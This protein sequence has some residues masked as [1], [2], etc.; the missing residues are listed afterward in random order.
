M[1]NFLKWFISLAAIGSAIGLI[2]AYFCKSGC[3][4]D[5]CDDSQNFTED[6]DFDL[7]SDLEPVPER[8]YVPLNRAAEEVPGTDTVAEQNAPEVPASDDDVDAPVEEKE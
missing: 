3:C 2:I 8:E 4:D 1:K 5:C 6:D 7:D